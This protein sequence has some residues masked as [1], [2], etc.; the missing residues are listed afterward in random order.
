MG[1]S[2]NRRQ[3]LFIQAYIANGFSAVNAYMEIYKDVSYDVARANSSNLLSKPNI[4]EEVDSQ[5]DKLIGEKKRELTWKIIDGF[6]Q[7]AFESTSH[8][9]N[10][11]RAMEG[12]QRYLGLNKDT[13]EIQI[14][15]GIMKDMF[16][17]LK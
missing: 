7:M 17:A 16:D 9:T 14:N 13:K 2:I 15:S 11:L 10:K 1:Y 8:D 5:L 6:Y 4:R 3:R 12:L